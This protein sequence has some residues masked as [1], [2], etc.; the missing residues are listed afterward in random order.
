MKMVCNR[1]LKKPDLTAL[2]DHACVS[3]GK[4]AFYLQ[5]GTRERG[6]HL[7]KREKTKWLEQIIHKKCLSVYI[8]G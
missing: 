3:L 8:S 5:E 1:I 2:L 4:E 7:R 6:N